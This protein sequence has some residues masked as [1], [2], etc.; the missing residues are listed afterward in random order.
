M[1]LLMGDV[2][3]PVQTLSFVLKPIDLDTNME[4]VQKL[5]CYFIFVSYSKKTTK[6][7]RVRDWEVCKEATVGLALMPSSGATNSLYLLPPSPL[8]LLLLLLLLLLLHARPHS[9]DFCHFALV[10]QPERS[11][12]STSTKT[13]PRSI[14]KIPTNILWFF[15]E[16]C[17]PMNFNI[18][19]CPQY[20]CS[21]NV[22]VQRFSIEKCYFRN[23][24]KMVMV[25]IM[26]IQLAQD[27]N[28]IF[29]HS[30][31]KITK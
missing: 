31:Q 20:L 21:N 1:L 29:T 15:S 9:D 7:E 26:I 24:S 6:E 8:I 25:I 28:K 18:N 10:A 11:P 3:V 5:Y 2:S 22:A 27:K 30:C 17:L 13:M 14:K 16:I 23:L 4:A 12:S 19:I